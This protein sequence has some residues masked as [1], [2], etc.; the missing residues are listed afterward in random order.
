MDACGRRMTGRRSSAAGASVI[1]LTM[2]ECELLAIW[3]ALAQYIY[4]RDLLTA[5]RTGHGSGREAT[6][7][8]EPN[9]RILVKSLSGVPGARL[10]LAAAPPVTFT[11]QPL[12][13]SIGAPAAGMRGMAAAPG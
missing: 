9:I 7:V 6:A 12:F 11:S 4:R 3:K 13:R 2:F 8:T 10:Q 1:R 5:R